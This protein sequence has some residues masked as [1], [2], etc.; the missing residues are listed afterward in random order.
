MKFAAH[1]MFVTP[2][3]TDLNKM[4]EECVRRATPDVYKQDSTSSVIHH[5]TYLQECRGLDDPSQPHEVF[6]SLESA[7]G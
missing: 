4:R 2:G 3:V 1:D 6:G 7:D 5:H